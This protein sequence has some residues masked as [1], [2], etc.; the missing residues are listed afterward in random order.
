MRK[1][2]RPLELFLTAI[3][4]VAVLLIGFFTF[5]LH[6]G[7]RPGLETAYPSA[8]G[9]YYR[10]PGKDGKYFGPQIY[11]DTLNG[12]RFNNGFEIVY[13]NE[14][15]T[16]SVSSSPSTVNWSLYQ[17]WEFSSEHDLPPWGTT[18]SFIRHYND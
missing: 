7:L 15:G 14:S 12:G 2:R 10:S 13:T 6:A 17:C 1:Q 5:S 16:I 8:S 4:P 9:D 18:Y 3:L 11:S